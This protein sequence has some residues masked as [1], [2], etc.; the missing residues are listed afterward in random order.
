MAKKKKKDRDLLDKVEDALGNALDEDEKESARGLMESR[1]RKDE[2]EEKASERVQAAEAR[3]RKAEARA[4]RA[5]LEAE[6]AELRA[7][8]E[9]SA[10]EP[11]R[12]YTVQPG[13]NLSR[14]AKQIYGDASRWR[15][16]Y[17]LNRDKIENPDLIYPGQELDLPED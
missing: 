17:N 13:D 2:E 7:K 11:E 14:I 1:V 15:E 9:A 3:A 12:T 6:M 4:R 16:I 8:R 10:K 5:E